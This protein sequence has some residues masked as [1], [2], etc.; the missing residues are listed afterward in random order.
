VT[1][2]PRVLSKAQEKRRIGGPS[3]GRTNSK[4]H[5]MTDS[6]IVVAVFNTSPDTV[7]MLR[8]VLE[9]AGFVVVSVYT[10]E[11]RDGKVDIENLVRQHRPTV[12]IYD[13]AP[14]YEKNWREFQHNRAM[15]AMKGMKFV[16]TTTN[17]RQVR[18]IAGDVQ[19]VLEFVGKPYDLGLIV[20][21]V[22]KC[23]GMSPS[24]T[25]SVSIS[26]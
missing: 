13:I 16:I 23:F 4:V 18:E 1:R 3:V 5:F 10:Y 9:Q 19:P 2:T 21:E 8:I 17:A 11:L 6:P 12:A 25:S 7:E 20:N 15:D 26:A 22:K 14:P 24:P